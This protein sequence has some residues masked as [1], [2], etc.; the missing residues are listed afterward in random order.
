MTEERA[1]EQESPLKQRREELGLTQ[2]DVAVAIDVS[3]QTVSNWET[4]RYKEAKL[5]L[6][7]VKALCRVLNW[8]VQDLPDDLGPC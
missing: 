5:T 6:P 4:G 2:R 8:T 7:Q 1:T 3:V